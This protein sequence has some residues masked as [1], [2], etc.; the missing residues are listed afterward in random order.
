MQCGN[1]PWHMSNSPF[2][3]DTFLYADTVYTSAYGQFRFG[4]CQLK[5][6][7]KLAFINDNQSVQRK[8]ASAM[9]PIQIGYSCKRAQFPAPHRTI[10][11][12]KFS[13]R[14]AS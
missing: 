3:L 10:D 12:R 6:F 13:R 7:I 14:S 8:L 1:V 11:D 4:V 5:R 2:Q 9:K